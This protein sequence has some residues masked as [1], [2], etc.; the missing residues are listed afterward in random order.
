M[1]EAVKRCV[2]GRGRAGGIIEVLPVPDESK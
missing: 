1:F 2:A